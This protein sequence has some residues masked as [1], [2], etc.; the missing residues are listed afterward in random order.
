MPP[1]PTDQYGHIVNE[2]R[3]S[4]LRIQLRVSDVLDAYGT[5]ACKGWLAVDYSLLHNAGS[6]SF[7]NVIRLCA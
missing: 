7:F 5:F 1:P 4:S 6:I 3:H 2:W